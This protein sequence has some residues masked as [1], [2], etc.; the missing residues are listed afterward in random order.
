M[1]GN[2]IAA[3]GGSALA[4]TG[5]LATGSII[6]AI[7]AGALLVGGIAMLIWRRRQLAGQR[8]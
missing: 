1:Y 5:A 3:G 6:L 2:E 4:T 7:I 8:P